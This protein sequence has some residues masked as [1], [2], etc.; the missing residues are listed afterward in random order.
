MEGTGLEEQPGKVGG[1]KG[2]I[3]KNKISCKIA[4]G[5]AKL[6]RSALFVG[7]HCLHNCAF[8]IVVCGRSCWFSLQNDWLIEGPK[9]VGPAK[10]AQAIDRHQHFVDHVDGMQAGMRLTNHG[11]GPACW[12][13][14]SFC[15]N[16]S[17]H[18]KRWRSWHQPRTVAPHH[19]WPAV[20]AWAA[21]RRRPR[22][23]ASGVA[24]A[25]C[26]QSTCLEY[27][28]LAPC[29]NI[30]FLV[31]SPNGCLKIETI[32]SSARFF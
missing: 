24:H 15:A 14:R 32:F 20:F 17:S 2:R 29:K 22:W 25:Q 8:A 7:S 6:E 27:R 10:H 5:Q 13:K 4:F 16:L 23:S 19:P 26:G 18:H 1:K 31:I 21:A 9:G 12:K 3:I 11:R 30:Y 28:E